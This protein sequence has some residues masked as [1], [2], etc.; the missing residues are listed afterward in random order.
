MAPRQH[1]VVP[2]PLGPP[3]GAGAPRVRQVG[4][5][6]GVFGHPDPA[7]R[8]RLAAALG[9][10]AQVSPDPCVLADCDGCRL[11]GRPVATPAEWRSVMEG[12]RLADVQG[13]FALAWTD[14]GGT[15]HLARDGVGERT[16]FYAPVPGGLVFAS[17]V[18]ALLATGL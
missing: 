6:G 16:L 3:L 7:A 17:S 12:G 10:G 15:L 8:A 14:A 4:R 13:A 18:R 11:D 2:A 9:P 1:P 5:I